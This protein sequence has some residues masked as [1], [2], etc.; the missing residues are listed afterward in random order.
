MVE[1][2]AKYN[3]MVQEED[4]ISAEKLQIQNVGKVD[5]KKHLEDGVHQ[6]MSDNI[7]QSLGT[8]LD[9]IVF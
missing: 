7:L 9:T 1:L 4:K 6:L 2:A 3:K 8:M 5:P